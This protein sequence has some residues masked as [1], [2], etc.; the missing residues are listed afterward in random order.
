MSQQQP[1]P[2]SK[3][4]DRRQALLG[5]GALGGLSLLPRQAF[6]GLDEAGVQVPDRLILLQ[7]SGGNDGLNTVVPIDNEAYM[8]ARPTTGLASEELHDLGDGL[9]LHPSL[10]KLHKLWSDKKLAIVQAVG[11]PDQDRSHFESMDVWH[12]GDLEGRRLGSGWIGRA[13][14]QRYG[15]DQDPNRL[16]HV[17][18]DKPWSLHAPG[19]P[20]SSF[21]HPTGYRWV[22]DHDQMTA[23]SD[24]AEERRSDPADNDVLGQLRGVMRDAAKS[25]AAVRDAVMN[26][27]PLAAYPQ[28]TLSPKLITAAALV[29]SE[30]ETRVVSVE[31]SGFDTHNEQPATHANLMGTLDGCL[32]ALMTDLA[33][34]ERGRR[35]VVLAFSEFGRRFSENGSRG[36]DHGKAGPCFLLGHGV[37]GGFFGETPSL[38]ELDKGDLRYST[39]F[40]SV[41]ASVLETVLGVDSVDV[42]GK[43][44]SP[45]PLFRA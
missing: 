33:Q 43:G 12:A 32:D 14:A 25:S 18:V 23:A 13:C 30:L 37:R 6:A 11:Y 22:S 20:A 28:S 4:L 19:V 35:T 40:R 2:N 9:G 44:H 7:L 36:T 15:K 24:R 27:R 3:H 39:D 10:P 34:T 8:R 1:K 42:L 5:L 21:V 41:Y 16:I 31:L 29:Q 38:T 26:Y 45:L 17:G